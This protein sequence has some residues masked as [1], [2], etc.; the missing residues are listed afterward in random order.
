MAAA[1]HPA[2]LP[3]LP[4]PGHVQ[5]H[6]ETSCRAG[7]PHEG[8]T[9]P[10]RGNAGGLPA[11]TGLV[12]ARQQPRGGGRGGGAVFPRVAGDVRAAHRRARSGGVRKAPPPKAHAAHAMLPWPCCCRPEQSASRGRENTEEE[13]EDPPPAPAPAKAAPGCV[14]STTLEPGAPPAGDGGGNRGTFRWQSTP[15]PSADPPGSIP[16]SAQGHSGKHKQP[17]SSGGGRAERALSTPL[18]TPTAGHSAAAWWLEAGPVPGWALPEGALAKGPWVSRE[19]GPHSLTPDPVVAVAATSPA[20][21]PRIEEAAAA[22]GYQRLPG[23]E[24]SSLPGKH[25]A[26]HHPLLKGLP[27]LWPDPAPPSSGA[28]GPAWRQLSPTANASQVLATGFAQGRPSAAAAAGGWQG[29]A[30]TGSGTHSRSEGHRPDVSR[31]PATP[32]AGTAGAKAPPGCQAPHIC[33]GDD[34][35]VGSQTQALGPALEPSVSPACP[36]ATR[37]LLRRAVARRRRR[38][39]ARGTEPHPRYT[40]PE[41][42]LSKRKARPTAQPSPHPESESSRPP[43]PTLPGLVGGAVQISHSSNG[44]GNPSRYLQAKAARA[45]LLATQQLEEEEEAQSVRQPHLP[46][47]H[48]LD[49]QGPNPARWLQRSPTEGPPSWPPAAGPSKEEEEEEEALGPRPP[50]AQTPSARAQRQA[51]RQ[52]QQPPPSARPGP[53]TAARPSQRTPGMAGGPGHLSSNLGGAPCP[54]RDGNL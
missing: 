46:P 11:G 44:P 6:P 10:S 36:S 26:G 15:V 13:E 37:A 29:R 38:K 53:P 27:G 35:C 12:P 8:R 51:G 21:F 48:T 41:R 43:C 7:L 25:L 9:G 33:P 45:H 17:P 31:D 20:A 52:Q 24:A 40:G 49:E 2:P 42:K 39:T 32:R 1:P 19:T 23:R 16:E 3:A 18:A 54:P 28:Q 22:G 4:C 50:G 30:Q 5:L 34:A 47:P 14:S